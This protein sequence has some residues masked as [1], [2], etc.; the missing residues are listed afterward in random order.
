MRGAAYHNRKVRLLTLLMILSAAWAFGSHQKHFV[1][2]LAE[3]KVSEFLGNKLAVKIGAINGGIFGDMV[4]GDVEFYAGSK[5]KPFVVERV[6]VSYRLWDVVA[7]RLKISNP[8]GNPVKNIAVY[9]SDDNAFIRGFIKFYKYPGKMEI[10]GHLSPLLF[11]EGKKGIIGSLTRR[12]D[13]RYDCDLL[14]GGQLRITGIIDPTERKINL[15][16]VPVTEKKGTMKIK[17]EINEKGQTETYY[18]LDKVNIAG[19]EVI[20]DIWLSYGTLG[21]PR[22]S[23]RGENI[24]I[25]KHPF[26]DIKAEGIILYKEKLFMLERFSFGDSM[27][28]SGTAH[29]NPPYDTDMKF[30]M[31][32][33]D[34]AEIKTVFTDGNMPIAGT[35]KGEVGIKGPAISARVDGRIYVASGVIGAL[36]FRSIFATLKGNFPVIEITDSRVIKDGGR[37]TVDGKMDFSK[38]G[39]G[40]AFDGVTFETDNKV[41]VWETWQIEKEED[42]NVVQASK[43]RFTLSTAIES[44]GKILEDYMTDQKQKE[45]GFSYKIDEQNSLKLE[46]DE[47]TDF[48]GVEHKIQF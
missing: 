15:D 23:A 38:M 47:E 8:S 4:L 33:L 26:W 30:V 28:L 39:E 17:G 31:N 43:D 21:T 11:G 12:E 3:K 6:E 42:G 32:D 48:F 2:D 36:N 41:A 27:M 29:M 40:K 10:F 44:E 45:M 16:L 22:F 35:V 18:R 14:W 5:S 19:S 13:A 24:V 37:I 1:K 9:F 46:V 7:E 20:G 25:N 34:L